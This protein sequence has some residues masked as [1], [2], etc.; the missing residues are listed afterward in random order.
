[1]KE[2]KKR[3]EMYIMKFADVVEELTETKFN[4]DQEKLIE[5]GLKYAPPPQRV[6]TENLLIDCLLIIKGRKF[7]KIIEGRYNNSKEDTLE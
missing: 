4:S 1:M 2:R 6:C 7:L 3:K 5:N